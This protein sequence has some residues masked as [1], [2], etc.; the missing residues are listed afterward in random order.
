VIGKVPLHLGCTP[1][2]IEVKNGSV[3]LLLQAEDGSKREIVTE[4]II[5]ATGYRVNL[6][7]LKFLNAEI[8]SQIKVVGGS[9]VLSSDFESSVPGLY[10]AGLAANNSFGPVMRFACGAGFAA[11]AITCALTKS[12]SRKPAS[13]PV[14]SVATTAK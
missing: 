12:L 10:F 8:R 9:P 5:A 1:Q 3:H 2:G 14:R 4:H 6:E 7:R 11:R 13:V